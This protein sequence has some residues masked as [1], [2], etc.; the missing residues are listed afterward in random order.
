MKRIIRPSQWL[1]VFQRNQRLFSFIGAFIV[2]GTF[3]AKEAISD[4]YKA[5]ADAVEKALTHLREGDFQNRLFATLAT[6]KAGS[7][8]DANA[9][10]GS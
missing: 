9:G 8:E 10:Q 6:I 2:F 5:R 3:M 1:G 7:S 4:H